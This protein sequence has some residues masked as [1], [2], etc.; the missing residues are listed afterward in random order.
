[1]PYIIKEQRPEI[2]N[3]I[4]ELP[5]TM[6]EGEINYAITRLLDRQLAAHG[7]SYRTIN[8]LMGV[9]SCAG[10]EFYRR[11]VAPYEDQ[12]IKQNGDAYDDQ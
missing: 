9:L 5:S 4:A 2:D 6:S 7:L 3:A 8:M 12:K 10:R 1:M 11:I